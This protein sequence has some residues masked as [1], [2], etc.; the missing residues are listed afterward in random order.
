L[1]DKPSL[2]HIVIVNP[3]QDHRRRIR[4]V[5]TAPLAKGARVTQFDLLSDAHPHLTELL[6]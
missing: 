1:A 5:L 4:T 3:N 2:E 6:R